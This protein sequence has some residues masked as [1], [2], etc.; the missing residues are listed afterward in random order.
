MSLSVASININGLRDNKK[1][2]LYFSLVN[3]T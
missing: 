1:E 2:K 3:Q